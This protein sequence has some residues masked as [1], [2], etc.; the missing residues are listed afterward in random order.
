MPR[1]KIFFPH[2]GLYTPGH[3]IC[4]CDG[5]QS[6]SKALSQSQS[7]VIRFWER[8][9]VCY[10]R[11]GLVHLHNAA[12]LPWFFFPFPTTWTVTGG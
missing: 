10:Y 8:A 9:P 3:L 11:A 4:V 2:M 12:V 7:T 1:N 5:E 6:R